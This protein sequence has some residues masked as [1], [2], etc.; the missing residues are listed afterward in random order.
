MLSAGASSMI[1]SNR[2]SSSARLPKIS[3]SSMHEANRKGCFARDPIIRPPEIS[4]NA[5]Q[6]SQVIG[7][8]VARL[9]G[10]HPFQK[11]FRE[12]LGAQTEGK[13]HGQRDASQDN[14]ETDD[15][16]VPGNP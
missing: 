6:V 2:A 14:P 8:P 4:S 5:S 12:V 10:K 13:R 11:L 3:R 7:R 15:D 1:S 9:V 16:D